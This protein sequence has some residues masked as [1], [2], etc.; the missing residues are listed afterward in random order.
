L[1]ELGDLD[2]FFWPHTTWYARGGSIA[3]LYRATDLPV[4]IA[5]GGRDHPELLD[6]LRDALP[7]RVYA[8]LS[9]GFVARLV[10]RYRDEPQG[11]Y[12]K[13][14]LLDRSRSASID[15]TGIESAVPADAAELQAFYARAYPGNWF[16]PRMLTTGQY[17]IRR[18]G[19]NLV[20][21]AGVHVYSPSQRVAALGNIAVSPAARGRGLASQVTAAL[22]QS[23]LRTTEHVGL[24]VRSD[25]VAA[26]ACY[27]RLGFVGVAEYEEH[28]LTVR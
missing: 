3:L 16:D 1:Y 28:L 21:A 26:L 6:E 22:C 25:N 4:L 23:L 14:A 13:M 8:H 24:N 10:P 20:A 15:T 5:L 12:V 18:E 27:K 11:T 7:T 2:D 19:G 17:K 9:P